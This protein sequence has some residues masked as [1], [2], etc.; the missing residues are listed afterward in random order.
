MFCM[1]TCYM[2]LTAQTKMI[3]LMFEMS[4]ASKPVADSCQA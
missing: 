4:N 2:G 1:E 3:G